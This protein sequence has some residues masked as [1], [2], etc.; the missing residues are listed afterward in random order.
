MKKTVIGSH[1]GTFHA[2]DV[3]A[4]AA[5]SMLHPDY[6]IRRSRDPEVWSG[7]DFLVDV[8]GVYD[9]Q[10]KIYDHHFLNGPA[11]DD[12]LLMSSVG[13][14]WKHYGEE[15]C[16]DSAIA[17]R[18]CQK[19]I[20]GLDATDNGVNL[21]QKLPD[22]P[23]FEISLSGIISLMNPSDLSNVD[24]IFEGEVKRARQILQAVINKARHWMDSRAEVL[25]ALETALE[26]GLSY[27]E[28]STDCNWGEHLRLADSDEKI[29]YVVYPAADQWYI[30]AVSPKPGVFSNRKDL[31]RSWAGLRDE[32]FSGAVGIS[33]GVF[34]HHGL[35]ICASKSYGSILKLVEMAVKA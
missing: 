1:S 24:E 10:K 20:R 34:C 19:L 5:L 21:T 33:D 8:G 9:H 25:E 14:V 26:K 27:I 17:K 13:L 28:V 31:P 11:Y 3:F 15:I 35:F 29:L 6:E 7:C 4:V 32:E 23:A 18:V 2:D 12:G 30:R 16:G 22:A